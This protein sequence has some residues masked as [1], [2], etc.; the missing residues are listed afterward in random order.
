[1]MSDFNYKG[2]KVILTEGKNDCHVMLALCKYYDV[3][4][5][6]GFYDCESDNRV[7]KRMSALISGSNS[8]ETIGV[9]LDAD[10]PNLAAKWDAITNRLSKEG[11]D[12]P[13]VSQLEGTI[14]Q[15]E[16]KPTLGIWLMPDNRIDGMLE[17]FCYTL[18]HPDA[19]EFAENCVAQAQENS[20]STFIPNHK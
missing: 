12:I 20:Y 13:D 16:D 6:F 3:P 19:V 9:V 18:A 5:T 1:M 10:N 7:L 15:I 14:L 4:E 11:Y 8:V 2:S 17:D